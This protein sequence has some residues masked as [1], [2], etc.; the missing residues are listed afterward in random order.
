LFQEKGAELTFLYTK[1]RKYAIAKLSGMSLRPVEKVVLAREHEVP[2]WL[3][4]GLNEIVCKHPIHSLAEL[5][6]KLG[7]DTVCTLLWIQNQALSTT[8][9]PS[10]VLSLGLLG[11]SHCSGAMFQTNR[12]CYNCSRI[13]SVDDH[14]SLYLAGGSSTVGMVTSVPASPTSPAMMNISVNLEHL[15]C[16]VCSDRALS[17]GSY[18]C[19]SCARITEWQNFRLRPALGV[20]DSTC[21]SRKI[22]QEFGDEI[23]RYEL[24]D[25]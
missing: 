25:Q 19:P 2:Q 9:S 20:V 7:A 22:L 21:A 4:E 15:K 13:I 17:R 1:I 16:R 5:K 23:S 3:K 8:P 12:D 14:S 24:W 18:I 10:V 11:C 6:S